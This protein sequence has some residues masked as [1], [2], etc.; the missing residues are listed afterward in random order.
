MSLKTSELLI[1]SKEDLFCRIDIFLSMKFSDYS[2]TYFQHLIENQHIK[3]NGVPVKKREKLFPGDRVE[4][5]FHSKEPLNASP[6]EIPLNLLYEDEYLL[7]INKPRGLV[8]HPA[9]GHPSNTLVNALL[10]HY[11]NLERQDPIRPGI[12]HRLDK[13]TSGVILIAKTSQAHERLS[14]AFKDRQI[15]KEY[16]ALCLGNPGTRTLQNR[17][18]RHP[19]YRK[20]IALLE[21]GKEAISCIETEYYHNGYSLVKILPLTGRTHQIRV[22]LQSIGCP[23][24]GDPLYGSERVNRKLDVATQMLHAHIL[25]F[26][27][28]FND[29]TMTLS[30]EIPQD[31]IELKK[32]LF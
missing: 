28:P 1:V 31:M 3:V 24:I 6:Q 22:H 5:D 18:G 7:A 32:R 16:L 29:T 23:V 27:H 17:L 26:K 2:R 9:P 8:I 15:H 25:R 30:A 13:D 21:Q 14:L 10:Y 19:I 20:K 11:K 4:I 12:I